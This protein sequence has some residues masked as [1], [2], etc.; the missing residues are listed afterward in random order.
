MVHEIYT[1]EREKPVVNDKHAY[2]GPSL[3]LCCDVIND[4]I[5]I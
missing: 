1:I 4:I 5:D 3:K 2:R